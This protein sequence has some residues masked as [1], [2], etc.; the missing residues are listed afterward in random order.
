MEI[1]EDLK[2]YLEAAPKRVVRE[3]FGSEGAA[4]TV[5]LKLCSRSDLEAMR[6]RASKKVLD[7]QTRQYHDEVDGVKLR[8][9]LRDECVLDWTDLTFAKAAALCARSLPNGQ[10]E[11]WGDK[12]VPASENNKQMLLEEAL[13][14]EEWVWERVTTNA[15]EVEKMAQGEGQT[16][17]PT[18]A[19]SSAM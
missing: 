1:V 7:R 14:F 8:T 6:K 3:T 12:P 11:Q 19:A 5:E 17:R 2:A 16:S 9:C 15:E 10:F 4:F 18:P 13:G